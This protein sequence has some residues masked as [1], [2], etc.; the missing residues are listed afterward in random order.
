MGL[1]HSQVAYALPVSAGVTLYVAATDLIPEVNREPDPR[2]AIL[3]FSGVAIML[4][5]ATSAWLGCLGPLALVSSHLFVHC[6][7]WPRC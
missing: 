7:G 1:L 6:I 5:P 4:I 2:M 3:V